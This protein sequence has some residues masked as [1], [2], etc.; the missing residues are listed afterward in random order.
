MF[1]LEL[2]F[3]DVVIVEFHSSFFGS[4]SNWWVSLH[5]HKL[6]DSSAIK[7]LITSRQVNFLF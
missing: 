2:A 5:Q 1:V 7:K 6:F 4:L 3:N